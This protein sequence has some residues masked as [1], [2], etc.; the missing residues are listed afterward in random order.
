MRSHPI[1][2]QPFTHDQAG[3]IIQYPSWQ[4]LFSINLII[5][6]TKYLFFRDESLDNV[7]WE[8]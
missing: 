6:A 2:N 5:F 8:D 7:S 4:R 1:D 3:P